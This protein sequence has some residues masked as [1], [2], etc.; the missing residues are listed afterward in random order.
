MAALFKQIAAAVVVVV[1]VV[2][3]GEVMSLKFAAQNL[4]P[5]S[6]KAA[7]YTALSVG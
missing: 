5:R 3:G 6:Q 7:V 2:G 1:V 4:K